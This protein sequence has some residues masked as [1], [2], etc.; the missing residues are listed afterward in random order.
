MEQSILVEIAH[1][2]FAV[3]RTLQPWLSHAKEVIENAAECR[4]PL[5]G[6]CLDLG[7][8]QRK[9]HEST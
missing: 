9:V 1:A 3:L 8:E 4:L 5:L 6:D 7:P 2:S